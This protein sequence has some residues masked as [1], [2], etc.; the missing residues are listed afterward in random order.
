MVGYVN[1][2]TPQADT[3]PA[4][5][6]YE[7]GYRDGQIDTYQT[8]DEELVAFSDRADRQPERTRENAGTWLRRAAEHARV[9]GIGARGAK[10]AA[11]RREG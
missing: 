10:E 4:L 8:M 11:E 2:T 1:E 7:R 3:A 6:D 9:W 5:T